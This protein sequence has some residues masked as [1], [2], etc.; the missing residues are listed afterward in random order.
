MTYNILCHLFRPT[1]GKVTD[2]SNNKRM[3][4]VTTDLCLNLNR[5][6]NNFYAMIAEDLTWLILVKSEGVYCGFKGKG[7]LK[8]IRQWRP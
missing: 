8:M 6:S 5:F 1:V 7:W 2:F 4:L 3:V